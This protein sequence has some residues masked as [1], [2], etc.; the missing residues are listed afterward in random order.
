MTHDVAIVKRYEMAD[1]FFYEVIDQKLRKHVVEIPS[2]VLDVEPR[3]FKRG[4]NQQHLDT[5]A[6]GTVLMNLEPDTIFHRVD[7][8]TVDRAYRAALRL[9]S[10]DQ[11]NC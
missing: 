8:E 1:T 6:C 10:F 2:Y 7:R 4:N 9:Q 11:L 3:E 5:L